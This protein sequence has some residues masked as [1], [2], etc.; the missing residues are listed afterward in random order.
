[1]LLHKLYINMA[2]ANIFLFGVTFSR[3]FLS[4]ITKN[5]K[6]RFAENGFWQISRSVFILGGMLLRK[7][8]VNAVIAHIFLHKPALKNLRRL[9]YK[10]FAE[11]MYEKTVIFFPKP[12][13]IW[14]YWRGSVAYFVP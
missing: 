14:L 4:Q 10:Q 6:C 8:Y 1:M 11:D 3:T 13:R 7:L 2:I 5:L 9:R 12:K